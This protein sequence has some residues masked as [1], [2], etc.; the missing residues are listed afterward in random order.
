MN[1]HRSF[2]V[3]AALVLFA[4]ER[5]APQQQTEHAQA[6]PSTSS[7]SVTPPAPPTG[8]SATTTPADSDAA[9]AVQ[10]LKDYYSAIDAR[11]F[12]KAY[13]MWGDSG[14]SSRKTLSD[15]TAG[16]A[17]TTHSA[18]AFNGQ[19]RIEGAAGSRYIDIPVEVTAT[20]RNGATQHF[21]GTYTLRRVVV[22]G[23]TAA[24]RV[25]H[26]YDA[27]LTAR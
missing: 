16:F 26:I 20:T 17:Q 19:G 11:Q 14:R 9:A 15:F 4:C 22:D 18:V 7:D 1:V 10:T 21:T 8:T 12:E 27:R 13:A 3:A 2:I 6:S 25:W 5:P 23:A 24:Q